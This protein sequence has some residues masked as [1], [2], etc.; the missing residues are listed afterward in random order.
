[1]RMLF[2]CTII[3]ILISAVKLSVVAVVLVF[4][5]KNSFVWNNS[6]VV[7]RKLTT[8]YLSFP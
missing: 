8:N 5:W 7:Y 1:M 2:A 3:I 4:V 6:F